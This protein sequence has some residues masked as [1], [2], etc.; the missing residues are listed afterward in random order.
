MIFRHNRSWGLLIHRWRKKQIEVWF[1]P[2]GEVIDPHVHRHV[3]SR[4]IWL[5]GKMFGMIANRSKML[6]WKDIFT[7]YLIPRNVVHSGVIV[8]AF[9]AFANIETWDT[10]QITSAATDFERA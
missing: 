10:N 5:G 1:C 4:I 8:G 6:G 9:C 2:K 7:S 3:D